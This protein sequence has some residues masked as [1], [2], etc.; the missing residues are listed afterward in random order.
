MPSEAK[1]AFVDMHNQY[2]NSIAR[3]DYG[4]HYA[5]A[6][7]M[8]TMQWDDG[9]AATAALN[10]HQCEMKHDNCRNTGEFNQIT[11]SLHYIDVFPS[12]SMVF[13]ELHG[14]GAKSCHVH[15]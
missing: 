7:N 2:R 15:D 5:Q 11:A 1:K 8:A 6:A 9:L 10:V 14:S 3:D 4:P 12:F 13:R